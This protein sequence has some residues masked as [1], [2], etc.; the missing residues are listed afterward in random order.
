MGDFS[1]T[2]GSSSNGSE[3]GHRGSETQESK[4]GSRETTQQK[5]ADNLGAVVQCGEHVRV[6][7]AS[8]DKVN[9]NGEGY[10]KTCVYQGGTKHDFGAVEVKG[11]P[12]KGNGKDE[13]SSP[14]KPG[15]GEQGH[16][17]VHVEAEGKQGGASS[18]LS[19]SI[20]GNPS[21][22]QES[23]NVSKVADGGVKGEVTP[24][25]KYASETAK[26][27]VSYVT[28]SDQ[29]GSAAAGQGI[30]NE[31]GKAAPVQDNLQ[32]ID[33]SAPPEPK[34]DYPPLDIKEAV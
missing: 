26:D 19:E 23:M 28:F 31:L 7:L 25:D 5:A 10:G 20:P 16:R 12:A 30:P 24:L 9:S 18:H 3:T 21:M 34:I 22:Y 13:P 2:Q 15:I 29:P 6:N 8:V 32:A 27:G 14:T 1:S 11:N 33:K 4:V 17:Q